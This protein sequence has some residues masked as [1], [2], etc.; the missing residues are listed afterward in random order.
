M[1]DRDSVWRVVHKS[2]GREA[3]IF[4]FFT[5]KQAQDAIDGWIARHHRGGRPDISL[6]MLLDLEAKE[7]P[8]GVHPE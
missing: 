7:F 2:T 1:T 3:T 6:D 8:A 4:S 5:R